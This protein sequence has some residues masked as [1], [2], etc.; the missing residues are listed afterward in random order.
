MGQ[1]GASSAACE[2]HTKTKTTRQWALRAKAVMHRATPDL[3]SGAEAQLRGKGL[4]SYLPAVKLRWI[5]KAEC[6]F[7][8]CED[9]AAGREPIAKPKRPTPMGPL[10]AETVSATPTMFVQMPCRAMGHNETVHRALSSTERW[11]RFGTGASGDVCIQPQAAVDALPGAAGPARARCESTSGMTSGSGASPCH[12]FR[13]IA[14]KNI[15]SD[16]K[17]PAERC[18]RHLVPNTRNRAL[19]RAFPN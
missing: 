19:L 16:Q 11:S 17:T 14:N 10:S 4:P 1:C 8:R 18:S 5:A 7:S 3:G 9:G 13:K 15:I 2:R 12:I 6:I